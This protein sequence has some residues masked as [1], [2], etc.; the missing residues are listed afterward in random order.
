MQIV[1]G[2]DVLKEVVA[3]LT[4]RG[5]TVRDPKLLE[6][7]IQGIMSPVDGKKW[8][9]SWLAKPTRLKTILDDKEDEYWMLLS[10]VSGYSADDVSEWNSYAKMDPAKRLRFFGGKLGVAMVY[11]GGRFFWDFLLVMYMKG[12]GT[13]EEVMKDSVAG[14]FKPDVLYPKWVWKY[15]R[16]RGIDHTGQVAKEEEDTFGIEVLEEGVG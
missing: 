5:M 13:L 12:S 7:C 14:S 16:N 11:P 4:E 2:F 9:K 3:Y 10:T 15:L 8:P 1:A 6:L